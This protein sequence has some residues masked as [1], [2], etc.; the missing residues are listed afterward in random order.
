MNLQLKWCL[1]DQFCQYL[2]SNKTWVNHNCLC[3]LGNLA[4][5]WPWHKASMLLGVSPVSRQGNTLGDSPAC[6]TCNHANSNLQF[7]FANNLVIKLHKIS[8]S[9]NHHNCSSKYTDTLKRRHRISIHPPTPQKFVE[10]LF[11]T[12]PRACVSPARPPEFNPFPHYFSLMIYY[13]LLMP[14]FRE[15]QFF[16]STAV[17]YLGKKFSSFLSPLWFPP[18]SLDATSV[19]FCFLIFLLF[20]VNILVNRKIEFLSSTSGFHDLKTHHL[21]C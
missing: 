8:F 3:L 16:L 14:Y 13:R 17:S 7:N 18:I 21:S 4:L 6:H 9:W 1:S 20:M 2:L 5:D 15:L 11:C 19:L 12:L 10:E